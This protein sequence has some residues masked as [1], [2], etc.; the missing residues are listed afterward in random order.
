[1]RVSDRFTA[2]TALMVGGVFHPLRSWER[3]RPPWFSRAER[4]DDYQL[5]LCVMLIFR[6][7]GLHLDA[8]IYRR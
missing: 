2:L 3:L 7:L 1:M 8:P 6:L 5:Y 4:C